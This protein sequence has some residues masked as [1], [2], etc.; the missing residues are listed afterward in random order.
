MHH[1]LLK[2]FQTA[3]YNKVRF[4][5]DCTE[6]FTEMSR[7]LRFQSVTWSDYKHHNTIE[8]LV[9]VHPNGQFNFVSK[10]WSGRVSDKLLTA[11]CG[12]YNLIENGDL[13]MANKGFTI[14]DALSLRF[15]DSLLPPG[16]HGKLQMS[17]A[18]N[19]RTRNIANH[20]IVVE[21]AIGR[22]KRF[23]CLKYGIPISCLHLLDGIVVTCAA[24]SNMLPPICV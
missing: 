24:M 12:F 23:R 17:A 2:F 21:Q 1:I 8:F 5:V 9:S 11:Y 15:A 20:R 14:R 18:E 13:V 19:T 10:V 22:L 16:K 7:N 3:S 4:I 6:L